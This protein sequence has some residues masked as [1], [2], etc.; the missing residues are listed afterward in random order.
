MIYSTLATRLSHTTSI[1]PPRQHARTHARSTMATTVIGAAPAGATDGFTASGKVS[2]ESCAWCAAWYWCMLSAESSRAALAPPTLRRHAHVV[3]R[4]L[5]PP[6]RAAV[7]CGVATPATRTHNLFKPHATPPTPSPQPVEPPRAVA[8]AA[9]AA[10]AAPRRARGAGV[11]GH[12]YGPAGASGRALPAPR[13]TTFFR[14][15]AVGPA[16][17]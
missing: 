17:V 9:A 6:L 7:L 5:L 15:Q 1:T 13:P 8:A 16:D 2:S 11:Q 14:A 4:R 10:A 12:G 3:P